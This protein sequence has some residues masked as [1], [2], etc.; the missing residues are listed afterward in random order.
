MFNICVGHGD[1][2]A[3][4]VLGLAGDDPTGQWAQVR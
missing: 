3:Q 4:T 2:V 1:D